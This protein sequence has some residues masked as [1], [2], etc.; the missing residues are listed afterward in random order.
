MQ[1]FVQINPQKVMKA[2]TFGEIEPNLVTL[3]SKQKKFY[4]FAS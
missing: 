1:N 2:F 4:I 3:Q